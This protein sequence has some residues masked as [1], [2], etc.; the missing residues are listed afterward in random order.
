MVSFTELPPELQLDGDLSSAWRRFCEQQQRV[1]HEISQKMSDSKSRFEIRLADGELVGQVDAQDFAHCYSRVRWTVMSFDTRND[2]LGATVNHFTGE[3]SER[4]WDYAEARI[5]PNGIKAFDAHGESGHIYLALHETA[6]TT[7]LGIAM[8]Q[9]CWDAH[10]NDPTSSTWGQSNPW[11]IRN[12][13]TANN[14]MKVV[15]EHLGLSYLQNPGASFQPMSGD[16][17][18]NDDPDLIHL[19]LLAQ[20]CGCG[21]R[22]SGAAV[23]PKN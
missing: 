22:P 18:E 11:W 12:E 15:A 1:G 19:E 13:K 16:Q 3:G 10:C 23:P 20:I 2:G 21:E 14:I 9:K 8:N 17:S 7:P 4:R 6:H 5:L